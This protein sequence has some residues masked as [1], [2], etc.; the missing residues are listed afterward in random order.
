MGLR[1]NAADAFIEASCDNGLYT[2]DGSLMR[3]GFISFEIV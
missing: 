2:I 3:S 1:Q